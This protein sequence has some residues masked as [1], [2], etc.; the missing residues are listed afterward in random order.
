MSTCIQVAN[1]RVIDPLDPSPDA[2]FIEDIVHSLANQCRYGGHTRSFYSVAQHSVLASMYV[3]AGYEFDA[4]MHDTSE[5][6]LV[7]VP[8]PLKYALFGDAY[9]ETENKLMTVIAEKYGFNW[10]TPEAVAYVDNALLRTEVR[11]LLVPVENLPDEDLWS[12]WFFA[13][14]IPVEIRPWGP[15]LAKMRFIERFLELGGVRG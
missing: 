1:G 4:L 8:S 3:E 9:R 12:P 13:D 2:I 11:D 10:P 7:D 15:E 6:Y 14:E 5:A